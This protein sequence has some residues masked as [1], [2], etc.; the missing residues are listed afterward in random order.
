MTVRWYFRR[1]LAAALGLSAFSALLLLATLA[2]GGCGGGGGDGVRV[3]AP[4]RRLDALRGLALGG[5]AAALAFSGFTRSNRERSLGNENQ[6]A[7][8]RMMRT[9]TGLRRTSALA[10]RVA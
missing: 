4:E 2:L 9:C 7:H 1:R 3:T 10:G 5:S 6:S 8:R